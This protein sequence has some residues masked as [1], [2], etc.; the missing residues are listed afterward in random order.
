M[1]RSP[2][3]TS[4]SRRGRHQRLGPFPRSHGACAVRMRLPRPP[5]SRWSSPGHGTSGRRQAGVSGSTNHR[6]AAVR[7][8]IRIAPEI[9]TAASGR[10]IRAAASTDNHTWC[11]PAVMMSNQASQISSTPVVNPGSITSSRRSQPSSAVAVIDAT[12]TQSNP[13]QVAGQLWATYLSGSV[14]AR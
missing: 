4:A 10:L 11:G 13:I 9:I 5:G 8:T 12:S 3:V 7:R 1:K 14:R 2:R 6:R